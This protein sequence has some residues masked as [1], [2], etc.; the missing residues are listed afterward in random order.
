[1]KEGPRASG[2]PLYGKDKQVSVL[3]SVPMFDV[4]MVLPDDSPRARR[5]DPVTSHEAADSNN[6]RESHRMVLWFLRGGRAAQFE[7]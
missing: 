6:V 7:F 4:P 5:S 3:E 2:G 1:M